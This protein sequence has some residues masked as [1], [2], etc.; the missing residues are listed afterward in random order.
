MTEVGLGKAASTRLKVVTHGYLPALALALSVVMVRI[1][2]GRKHQIRSHMAY[3]GHA[4]VRDGRY[5]SATTFRADRE[6]CEGSFLHRHRLCFT[7]AHQWYD[8]QVMLPAD[9]Q[10]A[11]LQLQGLGPTYGFGVAVRGD[12][13]VVYARLE[14]VQSLASPAR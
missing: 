7:A 5:S 9:L 2:T 10:R 6:L 3:I 14:A 12:R 13:R 8:I 4:V 1:D 11:L